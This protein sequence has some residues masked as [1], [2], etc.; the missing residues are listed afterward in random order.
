[1]GRQDTI[2]RLLTERRARLGEVN[3]AVRRLNDLHADLVQVQAQMVSVGSPEGAHQAKGEVLTAVERA[4]GAIERARAESERVAYRL[5][6]GGLVIGAVGEARSGKSRFLQSLTG[7]GADAVPDSAGGF[8]TGVTSVITPGQTPRAQVFFKS[9]MDMLSQLK[10]YYRELGEEPPTSLQTASRPAEQDDVAR[11]ELRRHLLLNLDALPEIKHLLGSPP[12]DIEISEV[13]NWVTQYDDAGTPLSLF[14]AVAKAQVYAPF[15]S[16]VNG[17]S[18]IDLP[19]LGDTN[20]TDGKRM[21]NA[22]SDDIDVVVVVRRPNADGDD[23]KRSD[24]QL[25]DAVSEALPGIPMGRRSFLLLNHHKARHNLAQ[26]EAFASGL[27]HRGM[28]FGGVQIVDAADPGEVAASFDAVVEQLIASAPELDRHLLAGHRDEMIAVQPAVQ[29]VQFAV[30]RWREA[31]AEA[32]PRYAQGFVRA[33]MQMHAELS[34]RLTRFLS[35]LNSGFLDPDEALEAAK[36]AVLAVART[37]TG[38]PT[39]EQVA[40]RIDVEGGKTRAYIALLDELR[41]HLGKH[42]ASLEPALDDTMRA[43]KH[44]V[45]G[46]L[47]SSGLGPLARGSGEAW[48]RGAADELSFVLAKDSELVM[49][50]RTLEAAKLSYRGFLQHRIRPCLS[51]LNSDSPLY[52]AAEAADATASEILDMLEATYVSCLGKV[53]RLLRVDVASEPMEAV[54]AVCEEFVDRVLRIGTAREEW[55]SVYQHYRS[56][57]W[58]ELTD[59]VTRDEAPV[60]KLQEAAGHAVELADELVGKLEEGA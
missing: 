41:A 23:W 35:D 19:G 32:S 18:V 58:P 8:C 52:P 4:L 43:V 60:R 13:R 57:L 38:L 59:G 30:D 6:K 14:R 36:A 45:V 50:L 37:D 2:D 10:D 12:R 53:E 39:V 34:Q 26:C 17:V 5:D 29:D 55:E 56:R 51:E 46:I 11:S 44:E 7:L 27:A 49:A 47:H 15:G 48:L 22:L 31:L 9:E 16:G 3:S 42:F 40:S 25:Y 21:L 33:R 1:M 20:L 28:E 54:R 24:V